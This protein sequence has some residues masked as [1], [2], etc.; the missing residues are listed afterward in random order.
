M[1]RMLARLRLQT[2]L[3]GEAR[4]R[5]GSPRPCQ[6]DTQCPDTQR[7]YL[8]RSA[9]LLLGLCG[10][11]LFACSPPLPGQ[12]AQVAPGKGAL[13]PTRVRRLSNLELE[14]SVRHVLA[15][16]ADEPLEIAS[17]LAPDVRQ[18]GY[19]LNAEQTIA[20]TLGVS[21][22]RLVDEVTTHA[23]TTHPERFIRCDRDGCLDAFLGAVVLRAWRR[24]VTPSEVRALRTLYQE[25]AKAAGRAA[26]VQIVLSVLLQS[27]S[28]L[29]V[30]ELGEP[31]HADDAVVQLTQ[32]EIAAALAY[33][34]SGSPPDTALLLAAQRG[35]LMSR[36]KRLRYAR[37]IIG[38]SSTR[39]HFRQFVLEWLEVDDLESTAKDKELHP[40]Y[41]PLKKSMLN[42]TRAFVDEV[43]VHHGASVSALLNG[44]FSSVDPSMARYYGLK[45]FG[46][47]VPL[48]GTRRRG[49]LQH[50]SFLARHAHPDSTS[51]VRRG[52]FVL[53]K[54]L[55]KKMPRP[56]ELGIEVVIPRPVKGQST[57]QRYAQ[58]VA[59]PSCQ[60]CHQTIDPLGFVFEAF[61]AAGKR[62]E[63]DGGQPVDTSA[64]VFLEGQQ[65][66]F[67]D[68]A[69]LS[70][71]LATQT[72]V[73]ECFARQAYRYFSAQSADEPER[74]FV[75]FYR[76]LE[77]DQRAS[78][79][80]VLLS[81]IA[82]DLFVYRARSVGSATAGEGA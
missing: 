58:H 43:M 7:S 30:T 40:R 22:S 18:A 78:L 26:G 64:T 41:E 56:A 61:D 32:Y 71:W 53:R 36:E 10:V 39:Y 34:L 9:A 16:E 13:L 62:R 4:C 69:Q 70:S 76:E 2:A 59:D 63:L 50:A 74:A 51:P 15:L 57:R 8:R 35:E 49:V 73:Q 65:L 55:C 3:A 52:D 5:S 38:R 6:R 48:S 23:V 44:G 67:K 42:E 60:S 79:I 75:D 14:R 80:D 11:A 19:T 46:P 17:R 47:V 28:F 1:T 37:K 31:S 20:S 72:T 29:Y 45:A 27:P 68:S 77:P 82:S 12:A 54:V 81:Y 21:W 66:R 25:G 24:P 33:T